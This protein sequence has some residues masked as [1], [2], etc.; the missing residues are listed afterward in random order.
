MNRKYTKTEI[1]ILADTFKR[2]L[3]TIQRWI[4]KK[5]DRLTSDK[6][7]IALNNTKKLNA[8]DNLQSKPNHLM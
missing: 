3:L 8:I 7:K 4:E 6:A 1:G 5:D 2:S